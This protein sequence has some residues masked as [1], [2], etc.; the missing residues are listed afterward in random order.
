LLAFFQD[1]PD[2]SALD[3]FNIGI[4]KLI[5]IEPISLEALQ[6]FVQHAVDIIGREN[7]L[8][9]VWAN[10]DVSTLSGKNHF[11]PTAL[12]RLSQKRLRIAGAISV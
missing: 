5:E 11:V 4:M 2:F 1:F 7:S 10:H 9:A 12:Q 6:A 8:A 3:D